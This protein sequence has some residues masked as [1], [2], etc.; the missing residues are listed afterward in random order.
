MKRYLLFLACVSM[1]GGRAVTAEE[2]AAWTPLFDGKTLSGWTQAG[3]KAPGKGWQVIDG[4]LQLNGAGGNLLSEKEYENFELEWQ[5]KIEKNGN[6]GIKYWVT[7]VGGSEWLGIEY[8]MID[9]ETNG[10]AKSKPSHASA[11][12]YDIKAAAA[13]KPLKA[14]GEWNTSKVVSSKGKLQ[15]FLNGVMVVEADTKA[16]EWK[17]LVAASKFKNKAGFAPGK[18]RIMLTDHQ[19]KVWIKSINIRELK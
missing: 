12:F 7:A 19:D 1:L 13:D 5:W 2:S 8:Q 3:G 17:Q 11:S 14:P 9:D 4:V 18:G 10:D 15:H 6:N 16:E